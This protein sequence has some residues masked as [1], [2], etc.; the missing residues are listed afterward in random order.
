MATFATSFYEWGTGRNDFGLGDVFGIHYRGKI[1]GPLH[2]SYLAFDEDLAIVTP[3]S[4]DFTDA[5]HTVNCTRSVEV[6][7]T[8]ANYR[9]PITSFP[10]IPTC[11]WRWFTSVSRLPTLRRCSCI[12]AARRGRSTF[13]WAS[14]ARFWD[15]LLED[16]GR[17]LANAVRWAVDEPQRVTVAG[18][19]CWTSPSG[20]SP[21]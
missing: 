9:A 14:I 1:P 13:R 11:R 8:Y 12:N 21:V 5:N 16:H 15:V 2:N 19:V 4:L 18:R 10:V 17:L 7:S 3:S 20:G 6:E